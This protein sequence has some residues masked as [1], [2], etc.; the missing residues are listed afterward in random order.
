[1]LIFLDE[2]LLWYHLLDLRVH[3]HKRGVNCGVRF[4]QLFWQTVLDPVRTGCSWVVQKRK[5]NE[6]ECGNNGHKIFTVSGNKLGTCL[7][8][9]F[10]K[11]SESVKQRK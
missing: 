6:F 4:S 1:M 2:N 8:G 5:S 7:D 11:C 9:L 10:V 3:S